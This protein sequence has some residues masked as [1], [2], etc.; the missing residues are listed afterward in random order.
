[1][2]K[3]TL[4]QGQTAPFVMELPPYHLP[5]LRGILLH[6]WERTQELHRPRGQGHRADGAGP[7]RAQLRRH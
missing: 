3:N 6:T 1:M 5:T 2:L 4:L 7:E